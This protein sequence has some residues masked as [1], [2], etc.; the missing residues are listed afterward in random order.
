MVEFKA[1]FFRDFMYGTD[2]ATT[3]TD[4]DIAK[5][6]GEA[7]V[8]INPGLFCDQA[9]YTIAFLNLAAHFLVL[10]L[11]ASG[12]GCSGQDQFL[13][14]S[15]GAGSVSESYAIPAAI[16]DNPLFANYAKTTYGMKYLMMIYPLLTG[17]VF[18]VGG[19]THA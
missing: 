12:T 1:Y 8:T 15:K 19:A 11:K 13:I 2:I 7:A 6:I 17:V 10:N 9:T 14:Q 4:P 18:A 16:L 3:V 5:A